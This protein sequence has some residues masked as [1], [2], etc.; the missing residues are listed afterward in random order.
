MKLY[1]LTGEALRR[2]AEQLDL[3]EVEEAAESIEGTERGHGPPHTLFH[4]TSEEG[5]EGILND[6]E[7]RP[8]D[9]E[10][11]VSFSAKPLRGG[12]IEGSDEV[13]EVAMPENVMKVEYTRKWFDE[14]P[15]HAA[16]VAGEGWVAQFTYSDE[17]MDEEGFP[18]EERE[19]EEFEEGMFEAFI[20]KDTEEEWIS[21]ESGQPVSIEIVSTES[22][23]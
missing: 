21:K 18:I 12:D 23:N 9:A 10:G 3:P 8:K 16:Y 19:E 13:L 5:A 11:F 22:L 7:I 14:Y 4:T 15:E 17:T 20:A 2:I 1:G 6:E